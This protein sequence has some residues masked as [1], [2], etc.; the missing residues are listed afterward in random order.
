MK[1]SIRVKL[2]SLMIAVALL[3]LVAAM[4]T[5]AIGGRKLQSDALAESFKSRATSEAR[6]LGISLSKDIE[7]LLLILNDRLVVR[8]LAEVRE[9]QSP[10]EWA[11]LDEVWSTLPPEDLRIARVV[12]GEMAGELRRIQREDPRLVEILVTDRYGQLQAATGRTSDFYQGDEDWWQGVQANGKP[13]IYI[14]PVNYDVST[15]VWSVDL[16]LPIMAG[17]KLAGV[18]KAVLDVSKWIESPTVSVAGIDAS[19]MFV[20]QDGTI[21]Y[22]ETTEPLTTKAIQWYGRIS[23][24][25]E[26]GWRTTEDRKVQAYSPVPLVEVIEAY[27]VASPRWS[28]VLSVP[29]SKVLGPVMKLSLWVMAVGM[30]FILL[31]FLSGIFLVDRLVIRR[32]Y[33][34]MGSARRIAG[35]DLSHRTSLARTD[36]WASDEIDELAEDFNNMVEQVQRSHESLTASDQLKMNFIRIA[37]HELRTPI[38]Y[39]L[40]TVRL[41]KDCTD[42]DRLRQA[43]QTM[44]AKARRLDEIIRAMFKLMPERPDTDELAYRKVQVS[45]LLEDVYLDCLP[46]V[47]QRDQRLITE[48]ANRI[49]SI[50]ADETKL[51][52]VLENLLLNAIKFTPDGGTVKL[53]VSRQLGEYVSFAIQDQGPGIPEGDLP[54]IFKPFYSGGDVM[55]HSS[56]RIEHAKKGMGLGLAIVRHFV[57]L[58]GGTISVSSQPHGCVFTVTIPLARPTNKAPVPSHQ[59]G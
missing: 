41:L 42:P 46:F 13:R 18:G 57:E 11:K 35:G 30:A 23:A 51:R 9:P 33:H 56:G 34:L 20:R 39:I 4:L 19:V 6:V 7:K 16:C 21:I 15:A 29:E 45:E 17:N 58:L 31:I 38:S 12:T 37:G 5:I 40:G 32:I 43:L 47:E 50:E 8:A 48:G 14:P 1:L 27:E 24:Q 2:V 52:D 55:K 28:Y 26:P 49:E 36:H 44:G 59:K 54:H 10:E 25:E 3:P 53:R 22:H